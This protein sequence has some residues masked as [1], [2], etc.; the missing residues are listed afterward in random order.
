MY[1]VS[2]LVCVGIALVAAYDDHYYDSYT[3]SSCSCYEKGNYYSP[4]SAN[5]C[6]SFTQR[7]AYLPAVTLNCPHGLQFN[8]ATCV[9]D[10]PENTVCPSHC[11]GHYDGHGLKGMTCHQNGNTYSAVGDHCQ[12]FY[13]SAAGIAPQLHHCPAGLKFNVASCVCDWPANTVCHAYGYGGKY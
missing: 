10:W 12:S 4:E 5:G 1:K 11:P 3:H 7:T 6:A 8:L 13:Q 9:C 2:L